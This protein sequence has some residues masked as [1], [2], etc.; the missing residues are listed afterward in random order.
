MREELFV[1]NARLRGR[2]AL[3]DIHIREGKF[4]ASRP[5]ACWPRPR[6]RG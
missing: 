3:H 1:K 2:D 5:P 6:T 4:T